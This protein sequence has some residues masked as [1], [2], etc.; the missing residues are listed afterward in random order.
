[1]KPSRTLDFS[2]Q[3]ASQV[4]PAWLFVLVPL[5]LGIAWFLYHREI[6]RLPRRQIAV[7]YLLRLT[8]VGLVLLGIFM[9]SLDIVRRLRFPGRILVLVDNSESMTVNDSSRP[10]IDALPLA[11]LLG[12]DQAKPDDPQA[13]FY[14]LSLHLREL[15][16][17]VRQFQRKL[18]THREHGS[19]V[20]DTARAFLDQSTAIFIRCKEG[21]AR[22][23]LDG[24]SPEDREEH[25]ALQHDLPRLRKTISELAAKPHR[26]AT[27]LGE[28]CE[29]IEGMIAGYQRLQSE[30]DQDSLSKGDPSLKKLSDGIISTRR[31]ELV[32]RAVAALVP[33]VGRWAPGQ[34]LQVMDLMKGDAATVGSRARP[35]TIQ[36][37]RGRTNL[38]GRL[39]DIIDKPSPFPLTSVVVVSDGLDLNEAPVDKVLK[40]YVN[41][42]VPIFCAG[43]GHLEEPYDLAI[44][45]VRAPPI[46]VK[47]ERLFVEVQVKAAIEST[48]PGK[49]VIR[50]GGKPVAAKT[51]ELRRGRQLVYVPITPPAEGLKRYT[52]ELQPAAQDAFRD[53]NNTGAFVLDVRHEKLRALLLDDRPRWQT[54]F[55]VNILNR[56]PYVD[57]N[58]IIR[59]MQEDGELKRGP[60]KGAWPSASEVLQI[61]DAVVLG[62]YGSEVLG[63]DEW[64]QLE[65]FVKERGK[66]LVLLAPGDAAAYPPF[67]RELFPVT[68]S[69]TPDDRRLTRKSL[70]DLRLTEEGA[71]HPLTRSFAS[72]FP[73]APFEQGGLRPGSLVLL[74]NAQTGRPVISC[75]SVGQGK[76]FMLHGDRL[77]MCLNREHLQRHAAVFMNL[78][79]WAARPKSAGLTLDQ[80]T[81]REGDGFQV[82]ASQPDREIAVADEKG[83]VVA[84]SQAVPVQHSPGLYRGVFAGLPPGRFFVKGEGHDERHRLHVLPDNEEVVTLA[85]RADYLRDLSRATGGQYR[86]LEEMEVFLPA[87]NLKERAE[88]RRQ[89]IQLWSAQTSLLF[90]LLLLAIE[91]ILRKYWSLV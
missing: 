40:Q 91:W 11:R 43:V 84:R 68:P 57:V 22:L 76:V 24:L 2:L 79:D 63:V 46:G 83:A 53:R 23:P 36:P 52:V 20:E 19:H 73:G 89:V 17:H 49:L 58:S 48:T 70:R 7:L 82:W 4:S 5:L 21:E 62:R 12:R 67:I 15:L 26:S 39:R 42:R 90:L 55:V 16:G 59:V 80:D 56:L 8:L 30:V 25:Q 71:L 77:W 86:P 47:D 87:M 72:H 65:S 78:I 33:A 9:P 45:D 32:N 66:A 3:F 50:D 88:M 64:R 10:A 14:Q 44:A 34:Y 37:V 29:T 35:L 28:I 69:S 1:M 74:H 6:H 75:R 41:R 38:R 31:L 85:Q 60:F 18:T 61:Y 54:R 51:F 27:S 13:G 81:L